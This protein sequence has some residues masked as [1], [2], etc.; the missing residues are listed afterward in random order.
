MDMVEPSLLIDEKIEELFQKGSF[1]IPHKGRNMTVILSR[2]LDHAGQP[3]F[4]ATLG[5]YVGGER[6]R[7]FLAL[8]GYFSTDPKSAILSID[9]DELK[10]AVL[11]H[12]RDLS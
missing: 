4:E 12:L 8:K 2:S 5:I 1:S 10:E 3:F 6:S 11:T 9:D 7:Q